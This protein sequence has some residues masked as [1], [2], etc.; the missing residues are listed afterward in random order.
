LL[1]VPAP[2]LL[3]CVAQMARDGGQASALKPDPPR[4]R[5]RRAGARAR[6]AAERRPRAGLWPAPPLRHDPNGRRGPLDSENAVAFQPVI[7]PVRA[8]GIDLESLQRERARI[9]PAEL[10]TGDHCGAGA[11]RDSYVEPENLTR[12]EPARSPGVGA[13]RS[14]IPEQIQRLGAGR[15]DRQRVAGIA[16]R[17]ERR[18][19]PP[20]RVQDIER[21]PT[22]RAGSGDA[23]ETSRS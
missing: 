4:I 13:R 16:R 5:R 17:L 19:R 21:A 23:I 6:L 10:L 7:R 1:A 8:S 22:D 11:L 12:C 3:A 2:G 20:G 14:T 18:D 9:E 15:I